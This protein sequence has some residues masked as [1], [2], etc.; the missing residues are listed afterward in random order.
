MLRFR[1]KL[2]VMLLAGLH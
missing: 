2:I 1:N